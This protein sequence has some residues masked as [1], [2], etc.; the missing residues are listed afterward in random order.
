MLMSCSR[1]RRT[2]AL[3][4]T[5][6]SLKNNPYV[7]QFIIMGYKEDNYKKKRKKRQ[8]QLIFHS[9]YLCPTTNSPKFYN[10]LYK[11]GKFLIQFNYNGLKYCNVIL[12]KRKTSNSYAG[13][14]IRRPLVVCMDRSILLV[15]ELDREHYI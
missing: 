3:K 8:R 7:Q 10:R 14:A 9:M 2:F 13:K 4:V 5:F 15:S 11:K 12:L 6:H 1:H